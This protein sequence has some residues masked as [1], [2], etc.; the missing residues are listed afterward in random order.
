[1]SVERFHVK[2]NNTTMLSSTWNHIDHLNGR[3]FKSLI[4]G[5]SVNMRYRFF[6][7]HY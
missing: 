2:I 6:M 3:L 5:E 7:I 4:C 1:M